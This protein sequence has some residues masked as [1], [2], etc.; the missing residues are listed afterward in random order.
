MHV[1][2]FLIMKQ[3]VLNFFVIESIWLFQD[4]V[5]FIVIPINFVW[6]L[7]VI[8]LLLKPIFKFTVIFLLV[9][10]CTKFVLLKFKDN[11]FAIS[12]LFKVSKT[13]LIFLLRSIGFEWV[14]SILVLSAKIIGAEVLF[15][16]LGRSFIYTRKS[17]G[18]KIEPC[19]TP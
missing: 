13:L 5:L 19:G 14:N 12:H 6:S 4:N 1:L 8:S 18:P 9:V 17:R 3:P 11:S 10:K 15:M 7:F 16:I 2:A